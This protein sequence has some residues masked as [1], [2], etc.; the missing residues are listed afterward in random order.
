MKSSIIMGKH[1]IADGYQELQLVKIREYE[2]PVLK[3]AVLI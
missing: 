3:R 1:F 2:L